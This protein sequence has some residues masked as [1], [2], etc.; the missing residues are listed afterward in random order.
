MLTALYVSAAVLALALFAL[1]GAVYVLHP[2]LR[3]RQS[4]AL[5]GFYL[6]TAVLLAAAPFA[7]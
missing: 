3:D 6:L 2:E 7:L 1:S 5:L 4:A